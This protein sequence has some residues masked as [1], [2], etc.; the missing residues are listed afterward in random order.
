M[1][2]IADAYS[3]LADEG[4]VR[5]FAML[6]REF[7][8]DPTGVDRAITARNSAVGDTATRAAERALRRELTPPATRLFQLF[9]S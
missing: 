8:S 1:G 2:S 5:F 3:A 6:A 7:W 4:R 9:P